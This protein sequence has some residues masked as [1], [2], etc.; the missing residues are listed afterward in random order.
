M[1]KTQEITLNDGGKN[2]HY[3]IKRMSAWE[4]DIW[5]QRILKSLLRGS[6]S[7]IYDVCRSGMADLANQQE[8]IKQLEAGPWLANMDMDTQIWSLKKLLACVSMKEEG[9]VRPIDWEQP[10]GDVDSEETIPKLRTAA[11]KLHVGF[12]KAEAGQI[13]PLGRLLA[14]ALS[15][16][17]KDKDPQPPQT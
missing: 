8:I 1:R 11:F 15:A 12:I 13:F 5:A 4:G 3:V 6:P 7:A 10:E 9:S 14:G 17:D 16:M 2:K